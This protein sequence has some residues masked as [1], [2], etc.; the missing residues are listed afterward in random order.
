MRLSFC[1][2]SISVKRIAFSSLEL[3][4]SGYF[5]SEAGEGLS[6]ESAE[7]LIGT[8]WRG[9]QLNENQYLAHDNFIVGFFN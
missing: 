2:N 5:V 6:I 3:Y 1:S 8:R 4:K 7:R 9:R